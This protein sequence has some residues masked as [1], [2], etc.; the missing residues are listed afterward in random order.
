[1]AD[2]TKLT[3]ALLIVAV[4][5]LGAVVVYAFVVRPA[6]TGYSVDRQSE[7]YQIAVLDIAQKAATCQ[8]VPITVGNQ[9][10]NLV[11][12]ECLQA[13]AQAQQGTQPTQQVAQ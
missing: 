4:V 12:L 6:V 11:A 2:K 10:I 13:Q 8:P 1:M 5:V 9:T 3:M 7:G